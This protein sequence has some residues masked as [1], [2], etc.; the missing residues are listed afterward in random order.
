MMRSLEQILHRTR[1][2]Q[3]NILILRSMKFLLLFPILLLFNIESFTQDSLTLNEFDQLVVQYQEKMSS[4]DSLNTKDL[5]VLVRIYNTLE[6]A[7]VAHS[8]KNGNFKK[9]KDEFDAHWMDR[10]VNNL[11]FV[12]TRGGGLYSVKHG[13]RLGY[14]YWQSEKDL[15][16][17]GV[18][19]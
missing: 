16:Q 8:D 6:I 2:I 14:S 13:L 15:F 9:F 5:I 3:P 18:S 7:E 12:W 11:H 17:V 19:E 4:K 10:V 1:G